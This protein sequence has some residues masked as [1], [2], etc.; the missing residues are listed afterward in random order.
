MSDLT[1]DAE[2]SLQIKIALRARLLTVR[3]SLSDIALATAAAKLQDQT[4]ALVRA[5]HPITIAAYVPIGSEPGGLDLPYRLAEALPAGGRLLLPVLLPDND[6]DWAEFTGVLTPAARGLREPTGPPL[7]PAALRAADLI[8]VPAL[9][10]A[11]DGTRMGRGGGSYDRA[12]AR[13][14]A[15]RPDPGGSPHD[16]VPAHP[17]DSHHGATTPRSDDPIPPTGPRIVALLHDGEDI[18]TVPAEP[19]DRRV[20]A[21]ITPTGGLSLRPAPNRRM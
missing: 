20:H 18:D 17:D 9:A 6:L 1:G 5:A 7:G 4:L 21:V 11:R 8:L 13:L 14:D 16:Q 12:L 10:V 15:P 2:K 3:R 19:H